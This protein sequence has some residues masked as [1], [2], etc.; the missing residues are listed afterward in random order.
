VNRATRKATAASPVD[1]PIPDEQRPRIIIVAERLI[2]S[3]PTLAY[4]T[5]IVTPRY[6]A[7]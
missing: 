2:P 3:V 7:G 5:F 4:Q 1:K 6:R